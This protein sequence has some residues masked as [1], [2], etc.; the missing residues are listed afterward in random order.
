MAPGGH[1]SPELAL[2][3]TVSRLMVLGATQISVCEN[4]VQMSAGRRLAASWKCVPEASTVRCCPVDAQDGLVPGQSAQD[5]Q[6]VYQIECATVKKT[7]KNCSDIFLLFFFNI[8][9]F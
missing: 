4:R 3:Q 2:G 1:L 5:I 9:S 6:G 8:S 7:H